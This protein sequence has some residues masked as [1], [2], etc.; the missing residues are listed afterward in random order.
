[1]KEIFAALSLVV[2]KYKPQS[3]AVE[4]LFS[5]RGLRSALV[6]AQAR[7]VALLVAAQSGLPVHEYPPA[8][9]KKSVGAG[10]AMGK[11]AVARM[12][13]RLLAL[14][15]LKPDASDALAVAIC[16][17]HH[18]KAGAIGTR[19]LALSFNPV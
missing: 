5:F 8:R 9:V 3:V 16:H 2:A 14:S 1:L 11:G 12:V 13:E 7:G 15:D 6:L 4:G 18:A 10:G 19:S 17:L